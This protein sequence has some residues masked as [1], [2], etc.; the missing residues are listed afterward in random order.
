MTESNIQ[1]KS[2]NDVLLFFIWQCIVSAFSILYINIFEVVNEYNESI[3][4][5]WCFIKN[6]IILIIFIILNKNNL[7]KSNKKKCLLIFSFLLIPDFIIYNTNFY[8]ESFILCTFLFVLLNYFPFIF[9]NIGKRVNSYILNKYPVNKDMR[10]YVL[11][12]TSLLFMNILVPSAI[13][14]Y[15]CVP[16]MGAFLFVIIFIV[17]FS[18]VSP[19][20]ALIAGILLEKQEY[21]YKHVAPK[22]K[23]ILMIGIPIDLYF[24]VYLFAVKSEGFSLKHLEV[25]FS[26]T[27]TFVP[28]YIV[29]LLDR[30][31]K[32]L[33]NKYSR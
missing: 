4:W 24:F 18:K 32:Y 25:P 19:I 9:L 17:L 8:D 11:I 27:L 23:Y 21:Y 5:T 3:M 28:L 12:L 22:L 2:R 30:L 16:L 1:S 29:Y 20:I 15:L 33:K 10:K 14:T 26:F 7:L 31:Y 6:I 13:V